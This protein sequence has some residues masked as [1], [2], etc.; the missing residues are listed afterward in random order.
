MAD[1]ALQ[2]KNMVESQVRTSDVTDR[3]IIAALLAV[4]R[5]D[6]VPQSAR[7][8]AYMDGSVCLAS[9]PLKGPDR[10]LLAPRLFARLLD[11]ARIE[12]GH[13]VLVIGTGT[14]YSAAVLARLS[15]R[16]V[17]LESDADLAAKATLN[18]A[19]QGCKDVS[20]VTGALSEGWAQSGPFDVIM[21]EG[22]AQRVP[23]HLLRQLKDGGVLVGVLSDAKPGKASI[24]KRL[25]NSF[26]R[27][28]MFDATTAVLPGFEAAP[29]FSL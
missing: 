19:A 16:V 5:E 13:S 15:A 2:R 24:W 12:P 27:R 11:L 10:L 6:F 3:R 29:A 8:V 22:A 23:D 20:V 21:I 17:A 25:G 1:F 28:T 4:P 26:D 18:L 7:T 14:G 9:A